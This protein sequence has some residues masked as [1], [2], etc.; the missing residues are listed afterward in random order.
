MDSGSGSNTGGCDLA[1]KYCR[2]IEGNKNDVICI[3]CGMMIKSDG[4]TR[5]KFHLSHID[6]H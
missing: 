3:F 6:P 5:F 2:P 4:I 1:L